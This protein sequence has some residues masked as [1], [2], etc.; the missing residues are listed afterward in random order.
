M[1]KTFLLLSTVLCFVC[2]EVSKKG[3]KQIGPLFHIK[4][5]FLSGEGEVLKVE[6][7]YKNR[8]LS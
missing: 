5:Y 1:V 6:L 8:D 7:T 2:F 4:Q 3:M